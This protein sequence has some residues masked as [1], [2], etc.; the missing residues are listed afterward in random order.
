MR[1]SDVRLVGRQL[2]RD[3][4]SPDP[5]F[6]HSPARRTSDDSWVAEREHPYPSKAH[7]SSSSPI[8]LNPYPSAQGAVNERAMSPPPEQQPHPFLHA[9]MRT[10]DMQA[11]SRPL[12]DMPYDPL[13]EPGYG[14]AGRGRAPH[15]S[16]SYTNPV[17][18]SD[19]LSG[20]T[21]GSTT[22][23]IAPSDLR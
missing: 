16:N 2:E 14:I 23:D 22:Y 20:T 6:D 5:R 4:D 19:D 3:D 8:P 17:E 10:A 11:Q 12:G 21:I 15:V 1:T 9:Q 18:G 13:P 7:P